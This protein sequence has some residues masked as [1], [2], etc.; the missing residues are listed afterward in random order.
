MSRGLVVAIVG[1]TASGKSEIADAV[2]SEFG[3]CVVSADAMQVYRGMDIGTAKVPVGKRSRPLLLVD[4]AEVGEAYSAAL[5]QRDARAAIDRELA[6]GRTPVLCGGTGLYV[7]AALD[8]MDFPEGEAESPARRLWEERARE[9]GDEGIW[10]ELERRD[11]ESAALIHPHNVR[12]TIRA[13]EMGERGVSYAKQVRGLHTPRVHYEA[14]IWGL[15]RGREA[16]YRSIDSRVDDM[17]AHGFVDE[18]R[19][20]ADKGLASAPTASQAIGYAEML[21]YCAG[22]MG[23]DDAVAKMKRRSRNYAKRQLTWFRRD[24]RIMWIDRDSRTAAEARRMIVDDAARHGAHVAED[25][26]DAR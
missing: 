10:R 6:E 19:A 20:L 21:A 25:E 16:L 11:P 17:L 8:E 13:L 18:V 15:A 3:S 14:R 22:T 4:V 2:A 24:P 5:Y 7:R 12:R 9:L 26:K 23:Y 1:P